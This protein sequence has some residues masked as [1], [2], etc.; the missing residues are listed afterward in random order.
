M[1][2]LSHEQAKEHLF[3]KNHAFAAMA[4]II[5]AQVQHRTAI[6]SGHR[7]KI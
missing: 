5:R 3:R 7:P 1:H 6:F 4:I 2:L